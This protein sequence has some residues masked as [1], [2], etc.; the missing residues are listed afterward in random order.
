MNNAALRK[1]IDEHQSKLPEERE[2]WDRK[3]SSIQEGF[4]KELEGEGSA[5]AEKAES[6]PAAKSSEGTKSAEGAVPTPPVQGSDDDA[7]LVEADESAA[8]TGNAGGSGGGGGGGKKKK[9]GKK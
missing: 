8:G 9:K 3:R 2:W 7:V 6:G 4:M 5:K 1:I